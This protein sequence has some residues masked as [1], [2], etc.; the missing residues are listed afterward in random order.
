MTEY[1][2]TGPVMEFD[3]VIANN[4]SSSTRAVSEKKARCNLAYQFKSETG[5]TART[6]ITLPGKLVVVE[7]KDDA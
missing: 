6:K 1:S 4:W 5:R 7:R 3:K 2:Y